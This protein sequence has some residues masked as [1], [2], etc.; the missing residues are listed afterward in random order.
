MALLDIDMDELEKA[1][2]RLKTP[3]SMWSRMDRV[4]EVLEGL[5]PVKKAAIVKNHTT[6]LYVK[7]KLNEAYILLRKN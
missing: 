6:L 3:S 2:M 7:D 1:G 4:N 5:D